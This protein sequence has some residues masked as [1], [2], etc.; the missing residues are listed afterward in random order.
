[1]TGES[2]SAC[3]VELSEKDRGRRLT[4]ILYSVAAFLYWM[5]LYLYVP[6]LPTYVQSKSDN[7]AMV[8]IVLSMYGLWQALIRLPLGIGSD[9]LGKRKPFIIGGLTL[10]ALGAVVMGTADDATGLL[11][12]RAISGMSA[13]TWVPLIVVFSALFP[14]E[15][16]VK[17]TSLI[18]L[19]GTVGRVLA[20]SVTGSLNALGGYPLAFFLAAG[21]AA[22]AIVII[23]C[24]KE[25]TRAPKA[26]SLKGIGRLIIRRDVLVP[27]L[28]SMVAQYANWA[29]TLWSPSMPIGQ[30]PLASSPFWPSSWARPMSTKAFC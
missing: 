5:G 17:A 30:P 14:P 25:E 9:W 18:T 27:S 23:V 24:N 7:L 21:S 11:I 22:L 28:L 2:S 4:I 20:T 10:V 16:A 19:I 6:T 3:V 1:L 13:A 15:D 8:G 12:G 29:A 26:P